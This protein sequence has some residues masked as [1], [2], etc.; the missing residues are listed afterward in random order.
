MIDND[1]VVCASGVEGDIAVKTSPSRP[2][3][4]F[5]GYVDDAERTA[6]V[7][8]A[9]KDG[10]EFYLTG[11]RGYVDEEGY[12]WFLARDDDVIITAGYRVGPFEVRIWLREEKEGAE[13]LCHS[14]SGH[15]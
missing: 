12:F 15:L 14:D 3:W 6:S 2:F 8:R 9:G 5:S 10:D 7:F 1:G 13:R 4:L 11:D